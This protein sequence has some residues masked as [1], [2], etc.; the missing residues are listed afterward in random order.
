MR[1]VSKNNPLPLYY[2]LKEIIQEM[3]ENEELK[4][5][6]PVPPERELCEIH[7]VSRMTAR[8][9]I[10]DLVN[11]GLLYREQG[12][13]TFVS[14]PKIKQ[15]LSQ[16]KGFTEDME[17]KGLKTDTKLLSFEIKKATKKIREHL[18]LTQEDSLII[19]IKRLRKIENEPIAVETAWIPLNMC[20]DFTRETLEGNSL[21]SIIRKKY[22]YNLDYAKQ[23]IEPIKI[24]EYESSLLNVKPESLALL[25]R[26]KTYLDDGRV[27]EYTKAIYRSDKYKYEVILR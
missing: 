20:P 15:Q 6:D 25:F 3:I 24:N 8:K 19:E 10:M 22:N 5:G 9:A 26:R 2:Q 23:T 1:K 14:A 13:G 21:Y 16:L 17:E 11:E 18:N 27:I 12:K 4:P 7:G